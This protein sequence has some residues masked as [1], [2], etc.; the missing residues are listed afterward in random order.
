MQNVNVIREARLKQGLTRAEL[1]ER[2]GVSETTLYRIEVYGHI[3]T[4]AVIDRLARVLGDSVYA[5]LQ[6]DAQ[7]ATR[8]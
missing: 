6:H 3:P 2:A 5:V 8:R 4:R 7:G 1:A